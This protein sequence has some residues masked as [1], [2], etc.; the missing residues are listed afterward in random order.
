MRDPTQTTYIENGIR[1][2]PCR[3]GETH[4]DGKVR[5]QHECYHPTLV[6][7]GPAVQGHQ[8]MCDECG[9]VWIAE[10]VS[11]APTPPVHV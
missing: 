3:C 9:K 2:Y 8:V 6:E 11:G 1:V 4:E 7:L 10:L 5:L